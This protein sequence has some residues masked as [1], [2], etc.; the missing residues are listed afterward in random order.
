MVSG[1]VCTYVSNHVLSTCCLQVSYF[2][3][4]RTYYVYTFY[5]SR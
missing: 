5:T 2:D 1:H 4:M 3:I